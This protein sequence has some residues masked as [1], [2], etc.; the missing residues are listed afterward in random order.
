P[1]PSGPDDPRRSHEVPRL[2][3]AH[4][5]YQ[6]AAA[7]NRRV[8]QQTR[9]YRVEPRHRRHGAGNHGLVRH[10]GAQRSAC[11]RPRRLADRVHVHAR[12]DHR[13]RHV[14]DPK[15]HHQRTRPRNAEALKERLLVPGL[16]FL[17]R[18][19]RPATRDQ[20]PRTRD[21]QSMDFGLSEEQELLQRSARDF[22]TRECPPAFVRD[23][24]RDGDGFSRAFHQKM[25]E[26]GWTGLVIPEKFGGLGLRLL[27][28]AVLAEEMGRAVLPGPF[29]SS[30][31]LAALALT[32]SHATTQKKQWL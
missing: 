23:M 12:L 22:L 27:D 15:E 5:Q 17:V 9:L 32:L 16:R 8:G 20:G 13:W 28:L 24:M 2:S 1:A 6:T 4:R 18:N 19:Q 26:L 14:A 31:V 25:A 21:Q 7:G 11:R 10:A 3:P 29:F 30:S